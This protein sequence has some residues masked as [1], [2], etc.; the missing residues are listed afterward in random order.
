MASTVSKRNVNPKKKTTKK[1]KPVEVIAVEIVPA[2]VEAPRPVVSAPLPPRSS[3]APEAVKSS[4]DGIDMLASLGLVGTV[5]VVAVA[6]HGIGLVTI[7]F[8]AALAVAAG[9]CIAD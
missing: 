3:P 2:V 9:I 1:A 7:L 5:G 6:A 8:C 4:H